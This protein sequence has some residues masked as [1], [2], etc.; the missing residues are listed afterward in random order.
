MSVNINMV[1]IKAGIIRLIIHIKK[2]VD[3]IAKMLSVANP[4]S[5]NATEDLTLISVIAIEGIIDTRKN[6]VGIRIIAS[7]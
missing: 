4:K 6:I 2:V 5:N 3:K 1:P 7:K